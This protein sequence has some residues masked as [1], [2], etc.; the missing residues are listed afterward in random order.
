MDHGIIVMIF[1][2]SHLI[3]MPKKGLKQIQGWTAHGGEKSRLYPK[4]VDQSVTGA[5]A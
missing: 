1:V 3:E 4:T 2:D 5:F